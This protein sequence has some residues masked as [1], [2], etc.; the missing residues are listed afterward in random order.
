MN[1]EPV[2]LAKSVSWEAVEVRCIEVYSD[3]PGMPPLATPLMA[4]PAILK[5][6]FNMSDDELRAR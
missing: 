1:N 2:L 4:G 3:R 6:T 5:H